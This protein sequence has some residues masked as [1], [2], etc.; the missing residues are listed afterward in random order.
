MSFIRAETI[1]QYTVILQCR[2]P[3]DIVSRYEN[4][5]TGNKGFSL[6]LAES[7]APYALPTDNMMELANILNN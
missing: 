3:H 7:S 4:L 5:C 1:N 6:E 2:P